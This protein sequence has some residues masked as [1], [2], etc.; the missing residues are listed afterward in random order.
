MFFPFQKVS[1]IVTALV[2]LW[3]SGATAQQVTLKSADG[4]ITLTGTLTGYNGEYY[5]IKTVY[6]PLTLNALGVT[7][8]GPGCPDPGQYAA[9]IT[10]SGTQTTLGGLLPGLVEDFA[11]ANG[12][13]SLRRDT[14]TTSWTYFIA[15]AARIP[16]ARIQA[17]VE[18]SQ[19]AFRDLTRR[20]SDLIATARLPNKAEIA[21]A[22]KRGI[23]DLASRYRQQIL[24]LDA[25]V[26]LVSPE[27]PVSSLT[28]PEIR[29]IYSGQITNWSQVGGVDAP[30]TVLRRTPDSDISMQFDTIFFP[31]DTAL[32][33]IKTRIFASNRDISEA[34]SSDPLAIGVSGFSGI[35]NAKPLGIRGTCGVVQRPSAFAL[36][37]GDY[38]LTRRFYLF[39]PQQRLPLFARNFLAFLRSPRAQASIENLG[40]VGLGMAAKPLATQQDRLSNA[41]LKSG[42]DVTLKALKGFVS[43]LSGAARLPATFRF[44]DNS[45]EIDSRSVRNIQ[46]LADMLDGGDFDGHEIIFA[47]FSDANGGA[48]GNRRIARNRAEQ[49]ASLIRSRATRADLSKVSFRKIGFGEVSP[50]ACNDS[51]Q[52]RHTNRRVEVWVR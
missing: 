34:V 21:T 18:P 47:G 27:N 2:L 36:R 42:N 11:F 24:A 51:V 15:D 7:C 3:F 41:I 48:S 38:P 35:R 9:D 1:V 4:T 31:R 22:K 32:R 29:G 10:L 16:V 8:S 37:S 40:F 6:G 49:V 45:T 33:P 17:R 50:I 12:L 39:T 30:I 19:R 28:M 46:A 14:S 52:G 5:H 13:T 23:G 26:L 44:T 25:I 20:K 43:A